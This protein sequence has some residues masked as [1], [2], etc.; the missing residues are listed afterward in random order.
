MG[1]DNYAVG[2][3]LKGNAPG[4]WQLGLCALLLSFASG[5]R[6]RS[7][8]QV[9][10]PAQGYPSASYV[11]APGAN[12]APMAA[13]PA[14]QDV[15]I[16]Q[17]HPQ[18]VPNVPDSMG[19]EA[20]STGERV[21]VVTYV[22]RYPEPV[23]HFP[24]IYWSGR[25]FYNIH[26]N[27]VFWDPFWSRWAYYWGPP[28]PLIMA[29]NIQYP[30]VAFS[31][32]RGFYGPGWYWGGV[33][34]MGFHQFGRPIPT[35]V[36]PAPLPA[37]PNV[38][39]NLPRPQRPSVAP[40]PN[41]R[42]RP[43][44]IAANGARPNVGVQG[45]PSARPNRAVQPRP[46][47]RAIPNPGSRPRANHRVAASVPPSR[48]Q[49]VTRSSSHLP[50]PSQVVHEMRRQPSYVQGSRVRVHG[51]STGQRGTQMRV[52][53][54]RPNRSAMRW[55]HSSARPNYS[56]QPRFNTGTSHARPN[57][58]RSR[59]NVSRSHARPSFSPSRSHARPN[60]SS[61]HGVSRSRTVGPARRSSPR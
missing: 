51:P 19:Q 48:V 22:H 25:W 47:G 11:Q 10:A 29:W 30:W 7:A 17:Q 23:D 31:W 41:S 46:N 13:N 38:A 33:N 57:Y 42:P 16:V 35:D 5:C 50:R 32:G 27:F 9:H 24:S 21:T 26:G 58:S 4:F 12:I 59:P 40:N 53:R 36:Q 14:Y 61:S 43:N 49:G 44:G 56:S 20:L 52:Y 3:Q 1:T 6:Q 18:A 55:G 54:P 2:E 39:S 8:Q 60:R 15:Q 37:R 45:R 28:H 34:P